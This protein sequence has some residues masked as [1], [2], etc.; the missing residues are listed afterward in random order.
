MAAPLWEAQSPWARPLT[1]AWS[2]AHSQPPAPRTAPHLAPHTRDPP[3]SPELQAQLTQDKD[4]QGPLVQH[5]QEEGIRELPVPHIPE[6]EAIQVHQVPH[7]PEEEVIQELLVR[8]T[9]GQGPCTPGHPA[10]STPQLSARASTRHSEDPAPP[11]HSEAP[12]QP[13]SVEPVP[14]RLCAPPAWV[15][16]QAWCL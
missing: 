9:Q 4:T 3:A 8:L 2:L 1:Q 14:R 5:I 10:L 12:V 16:R 13:P 11:T 7:I 15:L 6:E